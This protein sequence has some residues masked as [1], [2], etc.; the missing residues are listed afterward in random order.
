MSLLSNVARL[1]DD[2][3][4][5]VKVAS[6]AL[7]S[8]NVDVMRQLAASPSLCADADQ[9]LASCK[10]W[11][12]VAARV[13][14]PVRTH[15]ELVA[16]AAAEKRITVLAAIAGLAGLPDDVYQSVLAK[17]VSTSGHARIAAAIVGNVSV[18][19]EVSAQALV[20]VC[21]TKH[22]SYANQYALRQLLARV[23]SLSHALW[24]AIEAAVADSDSGSVSVLMDAVS[25]VYDSLEPPRS[26]Q[27]A[28]TLLCTSVW[29]PPRYQYRVSY[30][31]SLLMNSALSDGDGSPLTVGQARDVLATAERWEMG[32]EARRLFD[33]G[34]YA[35]RSISRRADRSQLW[36][37][38]LEQA[39][40][41][42]QFNDTLESLLTRSSTDAL[43]GH[44][45]EFLWCH[46]LATVRTFRMVADTVRRTGQSS[47]LMSLVG[48]RP[49]D[50]DA[51]GVLLGASSAFEWAPTSTRSLLAHVDDPSASVARALSEMYRAN[52]H[53]ESIGALSVRLLNVPRVDVDAVALRLPVTLLGSPYLADRLI[54]SVCTYLERLDDEA[55]E[56][57]LLLSASFTGTFAELLNAVDMLV[58][59]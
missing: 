58:A 30:V 48:L 26:A 27:L 19:D 57:A 44:L 59:A 47:S 41:S 51:V 52:K 34:R 45:V 2:P 21:R 9:L 33:D 53:A 7:A 4:V 16:F 40:T 5:Q 17:K 23:P 29:E 54:A 18:S 25:S 43:A 38:A 39:T 28:Y 8:N 50:A 14:N 31:R 13:A 42:D 1:T 37:S 3:D 32:A 22:I 36:R 20:A 49:A 6:A 15:D 12:V 56:R 55:F 11:K 24:S 46:E 35:S 10:D